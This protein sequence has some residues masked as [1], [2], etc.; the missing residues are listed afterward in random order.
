MVEIMRSDTANRTP[1]NRGFRP[2]TPHNPA[3]RII[4]SARQDAE[5]RT[6]FG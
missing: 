3:L 6:L 5:G 4:H 1:E 2:T